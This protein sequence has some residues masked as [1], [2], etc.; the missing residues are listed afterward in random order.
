MVAVL[1][2]DFLSEY[3]VQK[4]I[5]QNQNNFGFKYVNVQSTQ[6]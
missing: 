2:E 4:Q 5:S 1:L 6:C 3:Q